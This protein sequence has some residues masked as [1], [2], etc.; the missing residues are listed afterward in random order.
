L[1]EKPYLKNTHHKKKKKGSW[2]SSSGVGPEF[3][4]QEK[5]QSKTKNR[6]QKGLVNWLKVGPEF[7][8]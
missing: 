1:F 5:K 7:K 2:W 3:R 8:P 6:H 4:P